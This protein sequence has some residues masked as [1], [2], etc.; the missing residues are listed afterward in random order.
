[1]SLR[2]REKVQEVP[3]CVT[4][5]MTKNNREKIKVTF[6]IS[7]VIFI[8]FAIISIVFIGLM[9]FVRAF[10]T[11]HEPLPTF[12]KDGE[13]LV[14]KPVLYLY[15]QKTTDISVRLDF[16][17]KIIADYPAYDEVKRGWDV[18]AY[19]DG[20]IIN[21]TDG[22]EYSYIFWEGLSSITPRDFSRG[23]VVPGKDSARFLQSLL[24]KMGLTPKE[25]NEFIVYWYPKLQLNAYN[26]IYFAGD[27]YTDKAKLT[28][29]PKPDSV[30]RV[31]MLY[32]PL[33]RP[34]SVQPQE[35]HPFKRNGFTVVEWGGSEIK[36]K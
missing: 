32:K 29:S 23:F 14:G 16:D 36:E 21:H 33:D 17:G 22:K 18:T 30:L 8:F 5:G 3:R 31:Y 9:V 11:F 19:P 24:S 10:V 4:I 35:L 20:K 28:I 1:M 2:K 7:R 34:I 26:Y 13:M 25:Y 6:K 12:S 15:P 27:E